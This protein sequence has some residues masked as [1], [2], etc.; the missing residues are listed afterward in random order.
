MI[1]C[2]LRQMAVG[3]M[4]EEQMRGE[5][6][7]QFDGQ[8]TIADFFEPPEK[9]F[10]VSR[11]FARA[12]K[13][14]SLAEQKTFVYA[15]TQMRFTEEP[16]SNYVRLDK[17]VLANILGIHS[18]TNHLS[19]DVY[20]NIRD[21]DAH[22]RIE[23]ID[24][25]IEF[26]ANGF[27]ITSVISFKNFIRLR[28]NEDFLPLFTGLTT[29]Y[30][31]MWSSDIFKMTSA[32]S[33]KFYERLR[34]LTD[35]RE[36]VNQY[37]FGIKALKELFGIPKEGKGSYMRSQGGFNRSEF[38]KKVIDPI[39]EDLKR[40]RMIN[41]VVQPDGKYYEKLKHNGLVDGY[42]FYWTYTSHPAVKSAE[43]VR[44]IQKR[45]DEDPQILKVAGDIIDGKENPKKKEKKQKTAQ[46]ND[47]MHSDGF[48]IDLEWIELLS[49]KG[50]SNEEREE[51]MKKRGYVRD[52]VGHW[53]KP[54]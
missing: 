50:M 23:I 3:V 39:C 28:F 34:E 53:T 44:Q 14:M 24:K 9:L 51:V 47:F 25:D 29:N 45:V 15:L 26:Y 32:R 21:L 1:Y 54:K 4:E 20:D 6:D 13:E 7:N 30:L 12:R 18:D 10:A 2:E 46:Y 43:E 35:T 17:K 8:M 52:D 33:V 48:D 16:E 5:L 49:N 19:V 22:S 31:T 42:A 36:Q 40:C 11:V 27:L 38:E 37:G 41:L